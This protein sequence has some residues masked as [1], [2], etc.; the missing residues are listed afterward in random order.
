MF[1]NRHRVIRPEILDEASPEPAAVSLENLRKIN[2][3][4]GGQEVLR[5]RLREV[6]DPVDRFTMLDVGAASGDMGRAVLRNYPNA[7]VTSLDYKHN[8]LRNAPSPRVAADAFHLPFKDRS[9][10]F[11]HCSL[12]LHHFPDQQVVQLLRRFAM[13]AARAVILS[14]L[15]RNILPYYFLPATRW[16]FDWDAITLHDG[17]ISVQAAFHA[18]ELKEL[19]NQAGLPHAEVRVHRPAFR[20]SLVAPVR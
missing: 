17:P 4:L 15:E 10:D 5:K 9:F 8:H 1:I 19:A 18:A 3:L 11:V 20:L 2:R 14:D 13:L 16:L 6:A 7:V 12:F